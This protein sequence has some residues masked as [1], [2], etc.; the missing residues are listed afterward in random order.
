[1]L[2][3]GANMLDRVGFSRVLALCIVMATLTSMEYSLIDLIHSPNQSFFIETI[4]GILDGTP[5]WRA[6]ANRLAG[7]YLVQAIH[8]CGFTY[9][10]SLGIFY[11]LMFFLINITAFLTVYFEKKD[12]KA[13]IFAA[14]STTILM[15]VLQDPYFYTW[16]LIDVEIFYLL[17]FAINI[18]WPIYAY[19]LI[20]IFELANREAALFIPFW[21]IINSLK[22]SVSP[23]EKRIRLSVES[24][25]SFLSGM[26]FSIVS[27]VYTEWIRKVNFKASFLGGI[28]ED[29]K[30]KSFGNHFNLVENLKHLFFS[31]WASS[32]FYVSSI[33][34]FMLYWIIKYILLGDEIVRKKSIFV[35]SILLAIICFGLVNET[36]MYLIL[37]PFFVD[38]CIQRYCVFVRQSSALPSE[39][40]I[41]IT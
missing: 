34:F 22:L 38:Y 36:R 21:L 31:N 30:H 1:M 7:P 19:I 9:A 18:G 28:G 24:S 13:G 8:L 27:I 29:V 3:E 39:M 16:D 33:V 5:Q 15:L 17:V 35:G 26:I 2:L 23:V 6:F 12:Y 14:F 10:Q 25:A 4:T 32:H 11:R 37:I 40:K 41:N 20:F